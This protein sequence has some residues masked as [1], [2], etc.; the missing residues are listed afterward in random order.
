MQELPSILA[1]LAVLGLLIFI[2]VKVMQF[3]FGLAGG[4]FRFG[5]SL[6]LMLR[7]L[8]SLVV[9]GFGQAMRGR[10]GVGLMH[11]GVFVAAF[12]FLGEVAF[13]INLVSAMEH[14]LG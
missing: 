7:V 10:I 9:P 3:R 12:C 14:T 1:A 8:S 13:L 5:N 4:K 6:H 2:R 11:L